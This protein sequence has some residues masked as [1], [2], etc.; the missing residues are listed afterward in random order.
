[1]FRFRR[2]LSPASVSDNTELTTSRLADIA[3]PLSVCK[4]DARKHAAHDG[5]KSED[6]G[7]LLELFNLLAGW[8]K[9]EK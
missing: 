9:A 5:R 4:R 7:P 1:M 3:E 2:L 8:N 6:I